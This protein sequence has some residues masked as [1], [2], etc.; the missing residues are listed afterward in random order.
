MT[1]LFHVAGRQSGD[2]RDGSRDLTPEEIAG[3]VACLEGLSLT[4]NATYYATLTVYN[5]AMDPLSVSVS[6][7]GGKWIPSNPATLGTSQSVLIS[8]VVSL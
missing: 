4:H 3:G 7:E 6:A 1:T 2:S 8:T 5:A